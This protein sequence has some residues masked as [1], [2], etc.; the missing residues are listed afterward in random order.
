MH[1]ITFKKTHLYLNPYTSE[2]LSASPFTNVKYSL[3]FSKCMPEQ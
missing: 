3:G 1:F 2:K